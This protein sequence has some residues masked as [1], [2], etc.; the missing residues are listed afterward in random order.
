MVFSSFS[1]PPIRPKEGFGSSQNVKS[2]SQSRLLGYVVK[3]DMPIAVEY[4]AED[5]LHLKI[6]NGPDA[7]PTQSSRFAAHSWHSVPGGFEAR[8]FLLQRSE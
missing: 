2:Q 6:I 3:N 1:E 4:F 5:L 8:S 7:F